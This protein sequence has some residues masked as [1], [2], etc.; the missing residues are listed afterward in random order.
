MKR[1]RCGEGRKWTIRCARVSRVSL[2]ISSVRPGKS[3]SCHLSATISLTRRRRQPAISIMVRNGSRING[4]NE[5]NSFGAR[6]RGVLRRLVP[7]L[8][9]T[10]LIGFFSINVRRDFESVL[11]SMQRMNQKTLAAAWRSDVR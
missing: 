5:W 9:R 7:P 3:M 11:R 1:I 8:T 4:N 10:N 2:H 6:T